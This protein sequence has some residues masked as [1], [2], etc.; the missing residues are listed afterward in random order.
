MKCKF[1]KKFESNNFIEFTGCEQKFSNKSS[2][3]VHKKRE[4]GIS[5]RNKT[6]QIKA[7]ENIPILGDSSID[8]ISM[9]VYNSY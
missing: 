3:Y 5:S 4:H 6:E 7:I 9:G 1:D 8:F 2:V